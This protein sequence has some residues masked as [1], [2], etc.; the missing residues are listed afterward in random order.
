[1]RTARTVF[2]L[3]MREMTTTYGQSPGGYIW[4]VLQPL[5][6][7]I[8]LSLAFSLFARAPSL[9]TSFVLFYATGYMPFEIYTQ[10][11]NRIGMA[12]Q[13]SKPL[14]A[15]PGVTWLDAVLARFILNTLVGMTVFA[16]LIVGIMI[17]VNTRTHIDILPILTG[18]ALVA[19]IGLGVGMMNC[20]LIGYF[21]V[22]ER[23]WSIVNRPLFLASGIFFL[24]DDVP[25]IGQDIVWWNPLIHAIGHVRTGFYPSCQPTYISLPYAFAVALVLVLLALIFLRNGYKAVLER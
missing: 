12:L 24:Y 23:I 1:M 25:P 5:G 16:I 22:W 21:P 7:I 20:L 2:A 6:G 14:L 8:L 15:Y 10:L 19:L 17:V 18:V 13:Y 11:S 4:A 3:I 9:G